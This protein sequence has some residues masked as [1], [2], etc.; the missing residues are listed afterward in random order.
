MSWC[1]SSSNIRK[2]G[3]SPA[4]EFNGS[5]NTLIRSP[6]LFI[7]KSR[8]SPNAETLLFKSSWQVGKTQ[9]YAA[10]L[11]W[12][13]AREDEQ[14]AADGIARH[15]SQNR[16]KWDCR[17]WWNRTGTPDHSLLPASDP[18]Y[19]GII[20]PPLVEKLPP[21]LEVLLALRWSEATSGIN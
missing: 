7:Q 4:E 10:T 13:P 9:G 16:K 8:D 15:S 11:L 5:I 1:A 18:Y 17:M 21:H 3:L 6:G 20:L 14:S 12:I 19:S 2:R